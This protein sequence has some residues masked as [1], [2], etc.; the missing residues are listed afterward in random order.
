MGN[1]LTVLSTEV[2]VFSMPALNFCFHNHR[3]YCPSGLSIGFFF[4]SFLD[5]SCL[6]RPLSSAWQLP[7]PLLSPF[8]CNCTF[9]FTRS[10]WQ[11]PPTTWSTWNHQ[12]MVSETSKDL[13]TQLQNRSLLFGSR[14]SG[15]F[16]TP[17]KSHHA[18]RVCLLVWP[19]TDST[20]KYP[21][22]EYSGLY[23]QSMTSTE[24]QC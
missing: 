23:G 18:W 10:A 11:Q 15:T 20:E 17:T 5:K 4:L 6:K 2:Y 13:R 22:F 9:G 12:Q 14:C 16:L 24:A 8:H 19:E 1:C 21:M 3:S 7:S